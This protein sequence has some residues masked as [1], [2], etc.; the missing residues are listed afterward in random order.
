MKDN[1]AYIPDALPITYRCLPLIDIKTLGEDVMHATVADVKE[2]PFVIVFPKA[3][4]ILREDGT[5]WV[6]EK[7]LERY[8]LDLRNKNYQTYIYSK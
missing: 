6:E 8:W 7:Y 3:G 5:H 1:N 2:Y 4:Y